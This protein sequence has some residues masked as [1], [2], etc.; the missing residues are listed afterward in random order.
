MALLR[1]IA[2]SAVVALVACDQPEG[3]DADADGDSD[4]DTDTDVDA[5]TD[6]DVDADTDADTDADADDDAE[7]DTEADADDEVDVPARVRPFDPSHPV[8]QPIPDDCPLASYS[9]AVVRNLIDGGHDTFNF[10]TSGETPPIYVGTASDPAWTLEIEGADFLIHAPADITAGT[11][12]DYPLIVLDESSDAYGG[13]PVEYR[14][15]Q[16]TIDASALRVTCNG[17]GVG[18]Y[19]NDGRVHGFG[20]GGRALGQ[21]E[22]YGQN[23]GS[24]NSYTVG[25]IRP[26]DIEEGRIPHAIRVAASYIGGSFIWPATKTDQSGDVPPEAPMGARI[27]L[28]HAV[29]LEPIFAGLESRL[30]DPQNARAARIFVT[31][32]QEYGL[33]L[34]DGTGSGNNVYFEHEDTADWAPWMG[35]PNGYGTYNDIARAVAAEIPW[36]RLRVAHP[37]VFDGYG[38]D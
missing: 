5:D 17:G 24:G 1:M 14:M 31:A 18:V 16:A 30:D 11:G 13:H 2:P 26:I 29:D 37:D 4:S 20:D 8:Y 36:D 27:F 25:M 10:D 34:L 6:T 12:A 7:M 35:P 19:A 15:W 33:I 9:D 32:L 28:D 3:G 22:I 21:A 38:R 23:T